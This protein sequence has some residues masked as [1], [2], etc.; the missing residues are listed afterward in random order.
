MGDDSLL[1]L[2]DEVRGKTL[3][4]L[5]D[6][7]EATALFTPQGLKNH[8]L[9]HAGHSLMVVEHLGVSVLTGAEPRHPQGYAQLFQWGSDPSSVAAW[10][11]LAEVVAHL[12]EQHGRLARLLREVEPAKLAQPFGDP[13]KGRT[14][15]YA[16]IH[17]LHDEAGH[18]GEV[19]LLKKMASKARG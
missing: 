8:I 16:V 7:D 2:A 17:G 18:Q 19:W 1:M 12:K 3:R 9:W 4:L 14:I 6:V 5:S 11:S 15:R 10:P 13:T